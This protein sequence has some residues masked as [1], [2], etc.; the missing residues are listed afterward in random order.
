MIGTLGA[1]LRRRA[2]RWP[3]KVLIWAGVT[4]KLMWVHF[5]DGMFLAAMFTIVAALLALYALR[6][7]PEQ[8][9]R[10]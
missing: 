10:R 9:F 5:P 8:A 6:S 1:L 4:W 3:L 7:D 2:V